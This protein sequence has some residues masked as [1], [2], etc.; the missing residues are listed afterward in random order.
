[1]FVYQ[2]DQGTASDIPSSVIGEELKNKIEENAR[3]HKQV[4][5]QW[6]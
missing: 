5:E 3:L 6:L 1:M 4:S 2:N